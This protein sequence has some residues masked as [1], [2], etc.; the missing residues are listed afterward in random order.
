M[1]RE[2]G[3]TT[4]IADT[5]SYR[6]TTFGAGARFCIGKNLSAM[7]LKCVTALLLRRH[8]LELAPTQSGLADNNNNNHAQGREGGWQLPGVRVELPMVKA[9]KGFRVCAVPR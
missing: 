2:D 5:E 8:S 1:R 4:S 9:V 3:G 7:E 6:F